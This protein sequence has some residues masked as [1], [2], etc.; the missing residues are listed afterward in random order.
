MENL[1]AQKLTSVGWMASTEN[2]FLEKVSQNAQAYFTYQSPK[3]QQLGL[4]V[5]ESINVFKIRLAGTDNQQI[6]W[7]Q[8]E[9]KDDGDLI[10]DTLIQNQDSANAGNYFGFYLALSAVCQCSILAWEQWE[11][12]YR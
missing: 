4:C 6:N 7:F 5:F 1:I 10:I 9:L 2:P 8:C 11:S 3:N 12:N